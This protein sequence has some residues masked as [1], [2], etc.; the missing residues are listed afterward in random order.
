MEGIII[1]FQPISPQHTSVNVQYVIRA[2]AGEKAIL[3]EFVIP[4]SMK[5]KL[6]IMKMKTHISTINYLHTLCILI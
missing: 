2:C 3:Q 5:I 6:S 1:L 4:R